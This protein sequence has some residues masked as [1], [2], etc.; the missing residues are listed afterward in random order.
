MEE[1][2]AE[3]GA[4]LIEAEDA[5]AV[6]EVAGKVTVM[7]VDEVSKVTSLGRGT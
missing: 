3:A 7:G 6:T 2:E 4:K 1:A 5:E